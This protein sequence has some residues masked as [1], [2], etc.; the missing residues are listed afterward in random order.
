[1]VSPTVTRLSSFSERVWSRRRV[2]PGGR[3]T[4]SLEALE[5]RDLPS[6]GLTM[7]GASGQGPVVSYNPAPV[8]DVQNVSTSATLSPNHVTVSSPT[9]LGGVLTKSSPAVVYA[10][11]GSTGSYAFTLSPSGSV[12]ATSWRIS[13]F[14]GNGRALQAYGLQSGVARLSVTL[15]SPGSRSSGKFYVMISADSPWSDV[16]SQSIRYSL[17]VRPAPVTIDDSTQS[18]LGNDFLYAM[19]PDEVLEE[20]FSSNEQASTHLH[21]P[22]KSAASVSVSPGSFDV[23]TVFFAPDKDI[24]KP[25]SMSWHPNREPS[26]ANPDAEAGLEGGDSLADREGQAGSD[27]IAVD[28]SAT[29]MF[30]VDPARGLVDAPGG[31]SIGSPLTVSKLMRFT[32]LKQE[33]EAGFEEGLPEDPNL[34]SGRNLQRQMRGGAGNRNVSPANRTVMLL[35]SVALIVPNLAV[36]AWSRRDGYFRFRRGSKPVTPLKTQPD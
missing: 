25:G 23:D 6:L 21:S 3:R 14:D 11:E 9:T 10:F 35:S 22:A 8:V 33:A 20:W 26:A 7:T 32:T 4:L 17:D 36:L 1:M 2:A 28:P 15:G 16:K 12:A 34:P 24:P 29:T 27:A 30:T 18:G 13:F 19:V 5:S 31:P